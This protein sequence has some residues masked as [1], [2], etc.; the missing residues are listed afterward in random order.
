MNYTVAAELAS[1][2]RIDKVELMASLLDMK[3]SENEH[4]LGAGVSFCFAL[5]LLGV[6]VYYIVSAVSTE[7]RGQLRKS[8][9][10]HQIE[11]DIEKVILQESINAH[12]LQR[13][14]QSLLEVR[15]NGVVDA[16]S[17][18]FSL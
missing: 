10:R 4:I 12:H 15:V 14:E 5:V 13:D 9:Q 18:V 11:R 8:V 6:W 17:G 1:Q 7:W 3:K 16:E 2:F